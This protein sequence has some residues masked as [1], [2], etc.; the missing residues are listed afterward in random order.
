MYTE[1]SLR[2]YC[3]VMR[4]GTSKGIYLHD[5]DLPKDPVLRDK[6]LLAIFGSPDPRQI[7]GLGGADVLTS[8]L[9]IIGPSDKWELMSRK[10]IIRVFVETFLPEL[11]HLPLKKAL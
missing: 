4:A 3:V 11:P 8:K 6:I 10:F 2:I 1:E 9:A 7:N 5:N